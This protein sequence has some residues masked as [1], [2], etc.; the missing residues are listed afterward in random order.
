MVMDKFDRPNCSSVS[1]N[2]TFFVGEYEF[3]YRI[4]EN[5]VLRNRADKDMATRT[6]RSDRHLAAKPPV[7]ANMM[8]YVSTMS[9]T[10]S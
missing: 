8:P 5:T 1:I 10:K 9:V 3:R 4:D 6:I 7:V 2:V